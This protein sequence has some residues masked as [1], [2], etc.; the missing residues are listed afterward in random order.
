M[1][2]LRKGGKFMDN[3]IFCK[4]AKGIINSKKYYEDDDFFI[5]ADISP[6][7]KKHYLMIPKVHYKLIADQTQNDN[8]V[9]AKMIAKIPVLQHELGLDG[10]YRIIINQGE[11]GGQEVPHLHVHVLGGE[12][13]N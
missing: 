10:G 9:L 4:I 5:I 7:A 2:H 12:K 6:K 8:L 11:N 3:C 1:A 13:L